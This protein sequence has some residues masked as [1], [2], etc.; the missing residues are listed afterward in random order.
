GDPRATGRYGRRG[1]ASP[2]RPGAHAMRTPGHLV[3]GA[4][5]PS[6]PHV[7]AG[8]EAMPNGG[9]DGVVTTRPVAT[10]VDARF[11]TPR[12]TARTFLIAM[13]LAEDD[14][15]RTEDAIAY[16]DLS[17]MPPEARNGGRFAFELE[18]I[19]RST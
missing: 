6:C 17:G 19:P 1:Q 11:R 12:A 18:F 14:P 2:E 7:F 3:L 13:N 5:L 15:R 16:L 4:F 9:T 8:Q 10:S